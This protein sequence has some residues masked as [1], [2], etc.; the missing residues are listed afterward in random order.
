MPWKGYNYEDAIVISQRLVKDD[1]LTSIK[2]E[3]YSI[4]VSDTKLGPEETTND[5]PGVSMFKLVNLGEDGVVRIGS[6]VK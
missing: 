4:E 5:I 1:E 3:E 6:V 2:I